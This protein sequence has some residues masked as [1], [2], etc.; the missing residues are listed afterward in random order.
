MTMRTSEDG[1]ALEVCP[2][3]NWGWD[4]RTQ[5]YVGPNRTAVW[6]KRGLPTTT[7]ACPGCGG[8][9]IIPDEGDGTAGRTVLMKF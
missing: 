2:H 8:P 5:L 9:D 4:P 1:P 3:C 6:E 7:A